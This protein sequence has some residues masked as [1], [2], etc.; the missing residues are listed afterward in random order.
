MQKKKKGISLFY[1]ET[2]SHQLE[3]ENHQDLM[4]MNLTLIQWTIRI[5]V[6]RVSEI[7]EKMTL[8]LINKNLRLN[9]TK[10]KS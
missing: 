8:T 10:N 2:L 9:W 6:L 7:I 3:A 5:I 1:K 4:R